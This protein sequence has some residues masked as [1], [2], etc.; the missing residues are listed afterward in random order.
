MEQHIE[1]MLDDL[2]QNKDAVKHIQEHVNMMLN[3]RLGDGGYKPH[4][5]DWK[6]I[7]AKMQ[8][9]DI[10]LKV[11]YF[12]LYGVIC[13]GFEFECLLNLDDKTSKFTDQENYEENIINYLVMD[14]T[15]FMENP[16][17]LEAVV[18]AYAELGWDLGEIQRFTIE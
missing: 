5:I 4:Q 13:E 8:E 15:T 16:K 9:K 12:S 11:A 6:L 3:I 10:P 1:N 14:C 2:I 7:E 18:P 17:L